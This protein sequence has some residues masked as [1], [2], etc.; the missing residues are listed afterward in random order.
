M[1]VFILVL[2]LVPAML[3]DYVKIPIQDC[4]E[5]FED[6][7]CT[8][9]EVSVDECELDN[10]KCELIRGEDY[11]MDVKFT[12]NFEGSNITLLAYALIG[13]DA[14]PFEGMN[15]NA[16]DFMKCPVQSGK[17]QSY[18]F[19]V[20]IG[21]LKPKGIFTTRWLMKQN[22]ENRCCFVNKFKIL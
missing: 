3:C 9:S 6:I 1:K 18:I 20:N 22:G 5:N 21:V 17:P 4:G 14:L 8:I 10:D 19:N 13:S 12:P 16:C 7:P 11:H 2:C 15:P